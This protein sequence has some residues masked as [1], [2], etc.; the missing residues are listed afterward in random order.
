MNSGMK[1]SGGSGRSTS[2][3]GIDQVPHHAAGRHRRAERDP[4]ATPMAKPI[5][6]RR[7]L[8]SASYQSGLPCDGYG[9]S[10]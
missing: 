5:R 6:I 8:M 7:R 4:A 1:A 2:M 3:T 9:W 10:R